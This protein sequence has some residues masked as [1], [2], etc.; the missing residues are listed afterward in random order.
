MLDYIS[1]LCEV[2]QKSTCAFHTNGTEKSVL[3]AKYFKQNLFTPY[4]YRQNKSHFNNRQK[5]CHLE[6]NE[7]LECSILHQDVCKYLT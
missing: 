3:N 6:V 5:Y 7:I 4:C 2:Q 1:Q